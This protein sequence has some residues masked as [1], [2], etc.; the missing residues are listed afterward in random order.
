MKQLA[1]IGLLALSL[2][3][4]PTLTAFLTSVGA[5]PSSGSVQVQVA[6]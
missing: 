4:L 2:A 5:D 1:I 6:P 3:L